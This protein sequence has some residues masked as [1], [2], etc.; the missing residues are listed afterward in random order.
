MAGDVEQVPPHLGV[1]SHQL[2]HAGLEGERL[3]VLLRPLPHR[4]RLDVEP[5]RVRRRRL[6][7]YHVHE[8][9]EAVA[10]VVEDGVQDQ[11]DLPLVQGLHQLP[12]RRLVA[13][14]GIDLQVVLGVVLVGAGRLEDRREPDRLHSQ[15]GEVGDLGDDAAQV[16]TVEGAVRVCRNSAAPPPRRGSPAG[17]CSDRRSRS[18]RGR[19][20]RR[21][22]PAPRPA[23]LAPR[24]HRSAPTRM[25]RLRDVRTPAPWSVPAPAAAV[26]Q[27]KDVGDAARPLVQH[28]LEVVEPL[29]CGDLTQR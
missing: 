13:E 21:R 7:S 11:L 27:E 22:R 19:S 29:V 4:I 23:R 8:R 3:V 14:L 17:R 25:R 2:G 28:P 20:R 16:A 24:P 5:R 12:E 15:R 6:A 26:V 18:G 1:A 10:G 9:R